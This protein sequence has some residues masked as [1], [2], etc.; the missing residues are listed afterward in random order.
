MRLNSLDYY[1]LILNNPPSAPDQIRK[2]MEKEKILKQLD[3]WIDKCQRQSDD[4]FKRG[5]VVSEAG[6]LSMKAAYQNVKDLINQTQTPNT[7]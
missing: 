5:M 2:K 7:H 6:S 4:F 3:V 1:S